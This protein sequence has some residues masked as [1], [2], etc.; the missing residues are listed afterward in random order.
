MR[1]RTLA[2]RSGI[3]VA[4]AFV[5]S[6]ALSAETISGRVQPVNPGSAV[7]AAAP[8]MSQALGSVTLPKKVMADG[9]P[10]A[11]G[12]Y[13]VRV[14]NE[15]VKAVVGQ[16]P[17]SEKWIEF[18]QGGQVK[19]RELASVVKAPDVKQVAEMTP[20]AAGATKVQTLKGSDYL[21]VWINRGGTHYLV[22]LSVA[23]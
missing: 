6:A 1:V 17:D 13:T 22:H 18:V 21:R 14:S 2:R 9:Q 20:P 23:P 5:A 11:A 4:L 7:D 16:P 3:P 12:T 15:A 10:L 8:Q 19:G